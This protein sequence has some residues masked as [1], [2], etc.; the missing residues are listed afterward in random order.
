[1]RYNE[2]TKRLAEAERARRAV[3]RAEQL[4]ADCVVRLFQHRADIL[5]AGLCDHARRIIRA[6]QRAKPKKGA[7]L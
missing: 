3:E 7:R 4:A 6:R 5:P 2:G 1:V